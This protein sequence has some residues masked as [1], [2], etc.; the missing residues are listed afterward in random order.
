MT[1]P[2]HR[3]AVI[4]LLAVISGAF[5]AQPASAQDRSDIQRMIIEEARNSRVPPALALAVAKVESNFQSQAASSAG[6]RGVM[7]I[8]PKT[9]RD[10]FGVHEDELW[11][12][13]LNIQLGIDYLDQL[14]HQYGRRWDL[15]LSHYNGGTLAGGPGSRAIP[16]A[17][18]QK[19]VADVLAWQRRYAEQAVVWQTAKLDDSGYIPAR[20]RPGARQ[21]DSIWTVAD[22]T[23]D[24]PWRQNA[25]KRIHDDRPWLRNDRPPSD[26]D[27]TSIEQRRRHLRPTL[28]DFA[29]VVT[30]NKG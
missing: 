4:A 24:R 3:R 14:Y 7:Q 8:M 29:S 19:Y 1:I 2:H 23:A 26:D 11:D 27:W 6:A 15:A 9:A 25:G 5:G 16:H 18:T 20:T 21:L 12:A 13:R 28:D 30:W 22:N 17:F 10:V